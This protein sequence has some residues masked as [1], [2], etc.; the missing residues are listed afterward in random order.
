VPNVLSQKTLSNVTQARISQLAKIG[1]P[2][3]S[4]T[5]AQNWRNKNKLK[6]GPKTLS[7]DEAAS[8]DAAPTLAFSDKLAP[9][10]KENGT[11]KV[12]PSSA[13]ALAPIVVDSDEELLSILADHIL[14]RN[15]H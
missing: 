5:A 3:D 1:I 7:H 8:I 6:R 14:I 13:L 15:A 11:Y 12:Q 2:S 4:I 9:A 10:E